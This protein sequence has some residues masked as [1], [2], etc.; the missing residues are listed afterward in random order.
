[1]SADRWSVCPKCRVRQVAK[2]AATLKA[3]EKAV[4]EGYGKTS[5]D[6]FKQL[7][8]TLEMEKSASPEGEE[9]FR[10]DYDIG[11]DENGL[12]TVD[13]LGQ[14]QECKFKVTY[15]HSDKKIV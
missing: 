9:T 6:V 15:R 2:R 7:V 12:F 14:C 11:T 8:H 5:I 3:A 13:Y 1:M 4:Q 10:E